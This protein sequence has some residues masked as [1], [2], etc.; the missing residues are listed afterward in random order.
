MTLG[1]ADRLMVQLGEHLGDLPEEVW[2][3]PPLRP[4]RGP[5]LTDRARLEAVEQVR[6]GADKDEIATEYGSPATR[7]VAGCGSSVRG[8]SRSLR[9]RD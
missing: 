4:R 1:A 2:A 3:D 8:L 6:A 9:N 7:S 5:L